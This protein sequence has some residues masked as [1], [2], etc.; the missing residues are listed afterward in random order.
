MAFFIIDIAQLFIIKSTLWHV[1]A[2]CQLDA[3]GSLNPFNIL[4]L[5][6]VFK[7]LLHNTS[8]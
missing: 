2:I 7:E 1:W 8:E 6:D 3:G 4:E 5:P